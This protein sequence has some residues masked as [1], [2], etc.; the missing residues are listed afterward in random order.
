MA[1]AGV[2][3][4]TFLPGDPTERHRRLI[5]AFASRIRLE[6]FVPSGRYRMSGR[7]LPGTWRPL[8]LSMARPRFPACVTRPGDGRSAVQCSSDYVLDPDRRE[9]TRGAEAIAVG[10]QVFDC[11]SIWCETAS[12]SSARMTAGRGV[13]R[14]DRLRIDPDQPY[15]CGAQGDRRQRRGA[16]PDPNDRPQRIPV[17]RRRQGGA[18]IGRLQLS[19]RRDRN[20]DEAPPHMRWP[21]PTS[22]PSPSCR[23]RT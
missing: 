16:A 4:G 10:P 8:V 22:P 9:L 13:G 17:R 21:F 7:L 23:S 2:A 3:M 20:S 12:A 5:P 19:K 15:Q 11:C 18:V 14:A 6:D 1:L